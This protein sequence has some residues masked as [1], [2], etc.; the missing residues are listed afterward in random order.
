MSGLGHNHYGKHNQWISKHF[1]DCKHNMFTLHVDSMI[2]DVDDS[3]MTDGDHSSGPET[4]TP[5]TNVLC[6]TTLFR[7]LC[8]LSS[9]LLYE[10]RLVCSPNV[11]LFQ[12]YNS[13]DILCL[14][15]TSNDAGSTDFV[16]QVYWQARDQ[17]NL[18][19]PLLSPNSD[20]LASSAKRASL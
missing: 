17:V 10:S 2:I 18:R 5:W 20:C 7:V 15:T 14:L 9:L 6:Y 1:S 3:T 19:S 16:V 8:V 4:F 12:V 13:H 11:D